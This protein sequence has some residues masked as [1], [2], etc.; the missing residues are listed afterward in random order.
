ML[1]KIHLTVYNNKIIL[2]NFTGVTLKRKKTY[3]TRNPHG[4]FLKLVDNNF[5]LMKNII[6]GRRDS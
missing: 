4:E 3:V 2:F 1:I 5:F 6:N